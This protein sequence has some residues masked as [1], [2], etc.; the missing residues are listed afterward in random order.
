MIYLKRAKRAF[1]KTMN[2]KSATQLTPPELAKLLGINPSTVKRWVD[3]GILPSD[4]TPG[5][6]R[7]INQDQLHSFLKQNPKIGTNSY[8]LKNKFKS[9]KSKLNW[10]KIYKELKSQKGLSNPRLGLLYIGGN[11]AMQIIINVVLPILRHIGNEWANGKLDIFE[12][13]RMTFVLRNE[14]MNLE[15][16][17]PEPASSSAM[18]VLACIVDEQHELPLVLAAIVLKSLGYKTLILGIN[19]PAEEVSKA[20]NKYKAKVVIL[21]KLYSKYSGNKYLKTLQANLTEDCQILLAGE[22]WK[23]STNING[24]KNTYCLASFEELGEVLIKT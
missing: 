21:E 12:E 1:W 17:I 9:K 6:H 23:K 18:V 4:T 7:R 14:L 24:Q 11:T 5:G 13:H 16:M 22:G 3:K 2:V 20:V 8:L 19:T 15:Q 10:Q